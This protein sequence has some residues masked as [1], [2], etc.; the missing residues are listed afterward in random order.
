M[1]RKFN[2]LVHREGR[3]RL[4]ATL[5]TNLPVY[6]KLKSAYYR[7]I[8]IGII[9][10][11]PKDRILF[12]RSTVLSTTRGLFPELFPQQTGSFILP[13][14]S[15]ITIFNEETNI[16]IIPTQLPPARLELISMVKSRKQRA[17]ETVEQTP[18]THPLDVPLVKAETT[19]EV[20]GWVARFPRG[21]ET[22]A[23]D[24][25]S[26]PLR[27]YADGDFLSYS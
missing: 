16:Q 19:E 5:S 7:N 9:S 20:P 26:R 6:A 3:D 1:S 23:G 4:G 11:G 2:Y 22:S 15:V 25:N 17:S 8:R 10:R 13:I 12:P 18:N 27:I 21:T 24:C 14:P